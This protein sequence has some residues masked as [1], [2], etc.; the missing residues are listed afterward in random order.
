M[1]IIIVYIILVVMSHIIF[2]NKYDDIGESIALCL[3][4]YPFGL[5]WLGLRSLFKILKMIIRSPFYI[6]H[7][8]SVGNKW[9]TK[10]FD[11]DFNF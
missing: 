10:V 3:F 7:N 1:S 11:I 5:I 2:I 4:F 6:L 9:H 8:I